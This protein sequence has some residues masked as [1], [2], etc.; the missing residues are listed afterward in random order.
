MIPPLQFSVLANIAISCAILTVAGC[1]KPDKYGA[2]VSLSTS[3][4]LKLIEVF[5]MQVEEP[6]G[7]SLS[8]D[9]RSLWTVSDADGRIYQTDLQGNVLRH[10]QSNYEDLEAITTID[11]KHLAYIAERSRKIVIANKNGQI[12]KEADI[13]IPGSD[14]AGPEAL[15]YDEQDQQFHLMKERPGMLITLNR[16]LEEVARRPLEIAQDYSSIS[17]DSERK[18]L[19][20]LSDESKSI[21]VLNQ[22]F[23]I[24]ESFSINVQ[25]MEGLALDLDH[26]LIYIIS[27]PLE[28]LYVFEFD[29]F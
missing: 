26:N 13:N 8:K 21:H 2:N 29:P 28:T 16:Q 19:W 25:Q 4:N 11:D 24:L 22:D 5:P 27:D 15:T 9:N 1:N 6:S 7:L 10:F 3:E 14:N 20:V 18:H 12:L 23:L 17:Y